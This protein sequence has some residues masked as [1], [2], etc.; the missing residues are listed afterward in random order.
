MELTFSGAYTVVVC[1][2]GTVET[3]R[4]SGNKLTLDLEAGEGAFL[5]PLNIS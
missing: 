5:I 2:G 4:V 1:R 3:Y